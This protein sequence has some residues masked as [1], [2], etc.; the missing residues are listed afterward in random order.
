MTWIWSLMRRAGR[1]AAVF[2]YPLRPA[3]RYPIFPL[4][5]AGAEEATTRSDSLHHPGTLQRAQLARL[6]DLL[7]AGVIRVTIDS[8]FPLRRR[9]WRMSEQRKGILRAKS[10]CR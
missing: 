10:C 1:P 4:G 8:V 9:R 6:A 3:A 2:A 5:F 7:D